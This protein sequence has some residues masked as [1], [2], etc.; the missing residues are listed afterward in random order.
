[1]TPQVDMVACVGGDCSRPEMKSLTQNIQSASMPGC[2]V[3][4]LSCRCFLPL[5]R[6]GRGLSS[7]EDVG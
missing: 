6:Y 3:G 7:Q 4:Y 5:Q 2:F 1:M